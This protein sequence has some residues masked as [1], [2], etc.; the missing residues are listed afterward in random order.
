MSDFINLNKELPTE[1][2]AEFKVVKLDSHRSTKINFKLY[3][4]IDFKAMTLKQAEGL[5]LR[6]FPFLERKTKSKDNAN[7]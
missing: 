6:K 7:S 1:V 4:T 2:A 3:G 5:L